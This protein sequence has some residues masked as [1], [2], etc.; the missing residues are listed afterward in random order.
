MIFV[1]FFN[2]SIIESKSKNQESYT[3]LYKFKYKYL[4]TFQ[5]IL[6]DIL[7]QFYLLFYYNN[8]NHHLKIRNS[9]FE[10]AQDVGIYHQ[11]RLLKQSGSPS[12]S[13]PSSFITS[14][15]KELREDLFE[16][17]LVDQAARA[18]LLEAPINHLDLLSG[19][20]GG[21]CEGGKLLRLVSPAKGERAAPGAP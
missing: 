14:L 5:N 6:S 15:R 8:R 13:S 2:L 11:Y 9:Q 10:R 1:T 3:Q 7:S 19:K 18:L 16:G 4:D 17:I 20:P 21:G 12:S